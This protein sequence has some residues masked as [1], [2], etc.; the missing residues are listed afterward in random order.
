VA[1]L[2][3]SVSPDDLLA[4]IRRQALILMA[5]ATRALGGT[6]PRRRAQG[7]TEPPTHLDALRGMR[8]G[9]TSTFG[10][11]HDYAVILLTTTI[12]VFIG[13]RLYPRLAS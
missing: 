12:L 2:S 3:K 9:S 10:L 5:T 4:R 6:A 11:R 7:H 1:F 8:A 13:A